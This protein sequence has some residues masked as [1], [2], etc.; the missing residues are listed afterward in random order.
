MLSC[1]INTNASYYIDGLCRQMI[2]VFLL[3]VLATTFFGSLLSNYLHT[4]NANFFE[5]ENLEI[6]E[7]IRTTKIYLHKLLTHITKNKNGSYA[8]IITPNFVL[9]I[10]QM[11]KES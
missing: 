6:R 11:I 8:I 9:F 1:R 2:L 3:H 7:V 4:L 10:F 5:R